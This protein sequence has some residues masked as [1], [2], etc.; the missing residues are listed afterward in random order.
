MLM[1]LHL[2]LFM[3]AKVRAQSALARPGVRDAKESIELKK[4]SG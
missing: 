3:D 2:L 4:L 1:G